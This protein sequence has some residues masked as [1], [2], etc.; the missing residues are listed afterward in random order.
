MK[1]ESPKQDM[2]PHE[3]NVST[4]NLGDY[5]GNG[6]IETVNTLEA[7][8]YCESFLVKSFSELISTINHKHK[9]NA[10]NNI[11]SRTINI[12]LRTF[13]VHVVKY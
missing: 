11:K 3:R 13:S 1:V 4:N 12:Y 5:G 2:S 6:T 9:T 10:N 7:L 8:L